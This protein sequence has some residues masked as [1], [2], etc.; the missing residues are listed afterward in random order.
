MRLTILFAAALIALSGAAQAHAAKKKP[1]KTYVY[2]LCGGK[3]PKDVCKVDAATRKGK[4]IARHSGKNEYDGVSVSASGRTMAL[5]YGGDMLR[6]GR[7]GRRRVKLDGFGFPPFVSAD[8]RSIGWIQSYQ[9][10]ICT[11]FPSFFCLNYTY[12][13]AAVQRRGETKSDL[14]GSD[15]VSAGWYRNQLLRAEEPEDA[16]NEDADFICIAAEDDGDCTRTVAA[17]PTRALSS[18]AAS[19]DGRYLAVVSEP[20]PLPNANQTSKGRIEIYNPANGR[21]IRIL[22]GGTSDETP[23]FSP[24]SKRVAFQR[25]DDVFSQSVRGGGARLI[26]R[27]L[28]VTGPSWSR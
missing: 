28:K 13:A 1:A 22:N 20:K 21:R 27:D 16:A 6:A 18:P 23:M 26:K 7:D 12:Y 9:V 3:E 4:R 15:V 17:D 5:E 25:G 24:D 19:P 2:G 14:K 8:G 11:S 10:P